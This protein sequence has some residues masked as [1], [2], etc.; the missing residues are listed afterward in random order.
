MNKFRD[1]LIIL[2]LILSTSLI[3]SENYL[4]S[5][6]GLYFIS[7]DP[8]QKNNDPGVDGITLFLQGEAAERLYKKIEMEPGYNECFGDGTVSKYKGN[9]E[10]NMS[11]KEEYD[12]N[13][14]IDLNDQKVY[15]AESC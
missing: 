11:P 12:C 3:A 5:I 8:I 4:G 15:R 13:F 14:S 7:G 10:C 9:V 1:V 6:E 2:I